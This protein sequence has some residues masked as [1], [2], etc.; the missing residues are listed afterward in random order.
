MPTLHIE[1]SITDL[2]TWALAFN[3]F[4]KVRGDA[5]V[6]AERVQRPVDNPNYVVVDLDFDGADQADAFL[7]FLKTHVWG[8]R[9]NSPGL[10][11][12]PKA[13]ILEAVETSDSNEKAMTVQA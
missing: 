6:R 2:A 1:H 9:E 10:A 7:G 8:I 4:A 3:R 13:M 11:G 12:S 5:G